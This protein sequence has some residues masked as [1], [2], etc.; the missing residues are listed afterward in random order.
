MMERKSCLP[1]STEIPSAEGSTTQQHV[2][3]QTPAEDQGAVVPVD[4]AQ[5]HF[6]PNDAAELRPGGSLVEKTSAAVSP[7]TA[8]PLVAYLRNAQHRH[9][10]QTEKEAAPAAV[11][12]PLSSFLAKA[13]PR[14]HGK[15]SKVWREL[16]VSS[17]EFDFPSEL[18]LPKLSSRRDQRDS[19]RAARGG[20]N[21]MQAQTTAKPLLCRMR[22]RHTRRHP[23]HLTANC[24]NMPDRKAEQRRSLPMNQEE[25]E[26]T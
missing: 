6:A 5:L 14:R 17:S 15:N 18:P 25:F 20:R 24:K 22:C 3:R 2:A 11:A 7:H 21:T 9:P 8:K 13:V 16:T 26:T 4:G 10:G 1:E 23:L 19:P 12:T